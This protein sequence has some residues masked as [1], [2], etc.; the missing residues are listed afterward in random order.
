M[1]F[2]AADVNELA[3]GIFAIVVGITLVVTYF[4]SKRVSS[5]TDFWAAGRGLTGIQ[6]GF[7]IAGDYMSAASFLGMPA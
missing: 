2:F 5:A 3:L 7:A 1:T 6:N 4:A